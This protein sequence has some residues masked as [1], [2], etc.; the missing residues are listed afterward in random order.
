MTDGTRTPWRSWV[1]DSLLIFIATAIL[2]GPLWRLKYLESWGSIESIFISDARFLRDH[3]FTPKWQPDWY[4]GTR[5]DYIYPP[6]LRY[7]TAVVALYPGMTT[8]RAYHIYI[9]FFYCLGIAG[10]YLL[11]R[12]GTA[13]RRWGYIAAAATALLSPSFLFLP[14]IRYDAQQAHYITQRLGSLIR[15]GEGPHISSLAWLEIALACAWLGLRRGHPGWIV[16]AGAA[17]GMVV[18]TNFYGATALALFFPALA[19]AVWVTGQDHRTWIRAAGIGTVAYGLCAFWFVPSYV[20][21]T[22]LNMQNVSSPPTPWSKWAA[23]AVLI[24]L[25]AATMFW[26]RGKPGLAWPVFVVTA[27]VLFTM[28]V[29]GNAWFNFRVMG[30]PGRHIPELDFCFI[31]AA[32][33]G[34]QWLYSKS[35]MP[36]WAFLVLGCAALYP[37]WDYLRHAWDFYPRGDHAG[38]IEYQLTRWIHENLPGRRVMATGSLRFWYNAWFDGPMV[39]GGSEQGLINQLTI[40]AIFQ[41]KEAPDPR[42]PVGWLQAMGADV[43]VTH[44]A[45]SQEEFKDTRNPERYE[46]LL[47]LLYD[48][49]R[50]DR[51]FGVPRRFPGLGRVVDTAR[52]ESLPP[53]PPPGSNEVLPDYLDVL[54]A[55]PDAPA[56]VRQ[57][58]PDRMRVRARLQTG[59]SL[60]VMETYDPNW[61]AR[62]NGRELRVREGPLHFMR[63]DA[64]PGDHEIELEFGLPFENKVGRVLTGGMV[65]LLAGFWVKRR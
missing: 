59:E 58:T 21:Q 45:N 31:L 24:V 3:G 46:S 8:A 38:R 60:V 41:V 19:W 54:E 39:G 22:L 33:L 50:G 35:W 32:L 48:N 15:Y 25:G 57:E 49:G 40:A 17:A 34:V 30:E 26:A 42:V 63:I 61:T 27:T 29:L 1:L 7:G 23:L 9:A 44:A 12:A 47:P 64:P 52:M 6:A 10:A 56:D 62:S 51:I 43:F 65:L 16:A 28:N 36:R 20:R 5:V 18:S 55:G 53:M 4:C 13:A 14:I 11:V 2:V 37:P